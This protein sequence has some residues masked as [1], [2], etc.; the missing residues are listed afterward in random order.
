MKNVA[1]TIEDLL[2]ILAGLQG[3]AKIQIESKDATIMH[4]VARQTFKGT[5]LT[6][7]QYA[8]MKEKLQTYRNQ[9]TALDYDFDRAVDA[10]RYPLRH[11]D[12]SKYIKL[13]SQ[14]EMVGPD[15][16]YESYKEKWKWIKIRFP[17][18]KKLIVKIQEITNKIGMRDYHHAKGS[19][20]HYFKFNEI[21]VFN[22]LTHFENS[23]FDIE[24][25]IVNYYEILKIMNNNKENYLPGIYNFKLCNL[26]KK[27]IDYIVSDIGHPN[28]ENLALFKDRQE[29]YGLH[30][31]DQNDLNNSLS[32]YTTL[33]NKIIKRE[34]TN[35]FVSSNKYSFDSLAESLLELNRFPL[36]VV[37]SSGKE[38][39][40]LSTVY[41]AFDGFI[42]KSNSTVMFRLDN[43]E[44]SNFNE[45]IQ[46]NSI[47]N[48]LDKTIQVV[49][50]EQNK[51]TKP[52]IESEWRPSTVLLMGS[53]LV[54]HK[55]SP[56]YNETD[57]I[58]HYDDTIS[59]LM[60][61]KRQGIEEL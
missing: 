1:N 23:S 49:Y 47:N 57:L 6:D 31:F 11:I 26:N 20:I 55:V 29:L 28:K 13:V 30:Y 54:G 35:V 12:R 39:E 60:R 36:L 27:A 22:V 51:I 3:Q 17:F 9:F 59:Q 16:V 41:R 50:T 46:R 38:L 4:S 56:Y 43:K 44:N 21:N 34:K 2:E 25:E 7:R 24:D 10:L 32:Y 61:F 40:L 37:L 14:Q 52:L 15:Q 5:A 45:Y 33:S 42:E 58:L 19:H 8:L 18:S 48:K 53:S